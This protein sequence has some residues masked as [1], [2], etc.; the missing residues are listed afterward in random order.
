MKSF[1]I[2]LIMVI[3]VLLGGYFSERLKQKCRFLKNIAYMLEELQLM[4]E[5]ESAEV[6]DIIHRFLK[7][8]RLSE[9]GFIKDIA[10]EMK[11]ICDLG[12]VWEKAVEKQ[13]Y[14]FLDDD[15]KELIKDI[16]R[17][18]GKSDI[19]GQLNAIRYEKA[20]IEKMIRSAEEETCNKSKL[21]RSLGVLGGAFIIIML[22]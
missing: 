13:Q 11:N 7:N 18:L 17:K 5:Y 20:E 14:G 1:F 16:G 8:N 19:S 12:I 6:N 4:I 10:D 2:I 9:L 22:I 21:Y 3:C 15:E